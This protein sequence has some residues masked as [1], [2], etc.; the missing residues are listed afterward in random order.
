[1]ENPAQ[2]SRATIVR[3]ALLLAIPAA[4]ILVFVAAN[5]VS[6]PRTEFEK[7][8]DE[9]QE[10]MRKRAREDEKAARDPVYAE[11]LRL[12]RIEE[13]RREIRKGK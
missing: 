1:M 2:S 12:E 6:D 11:A 9:I 8:R 4:L 5:W 13:Q 7:T 10:Y 3:V